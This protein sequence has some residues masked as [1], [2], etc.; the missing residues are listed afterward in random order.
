MP[1]IAAIFGILCALVFYI[2]LPN[3]PDILSKTFN[4][5]YQFLL[6]KWYF[7]ELYNRLFVRPTFYI[8]KQLWK[9][10]DGVLIDGLGPDGIS[11]AVQ[12]ISR[13]IS[14]L[15]SGYV[16]HYAFAMLIGLVGIVTWYL[17]SFSG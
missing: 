3:I 15:Q 1:L 6:K 2:Q 5:A 10:G 16:Y 13:R 8:A 14:H 7:D 4:R 17:Y 9:I 11:S 12:D